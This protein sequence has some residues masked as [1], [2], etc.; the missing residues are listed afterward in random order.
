MKLNLLTL[1]NY[2]ERYIP[3]VV[4]MTIGDCFKDYWLDPID[5]KR[6]E[7]RLDNLHVDLSMA[8]TEDQ[9]VGSIWANIEKINTFISKRLF[10]KINLTKKKQ[11]D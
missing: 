10:A 2:S 8:I 9:G 7:S 11:V 6:F 1:E 4:L 3:L 5:K